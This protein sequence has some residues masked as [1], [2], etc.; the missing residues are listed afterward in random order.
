MLEAFHRIKVFPFQV[1]G[2]DT[3]YLLLKPDQELEGIW[4]PVEG[5]IGFGDQMEQAARRCLV[6]DVG[7]RPPGTLLDLQWATRTQFGNELII[8]WCYGYECHENPDPAVL[9]QHWAEHRWAGFGEAYQAMELQADRTAMLRLHAMI[10]A[11]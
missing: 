1:L 8:E 11:A 5:E 6:Q 7:V 4:G 10:H 3:R 9:A 2:R